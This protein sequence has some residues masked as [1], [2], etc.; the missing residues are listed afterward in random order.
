MPRPKASQTIRKTNPRTKENVS[1]SISPGTM[2]FTP[3][4]K[5][6]IAHAANG[7]APQSLRPGMRYR[8]PPGI[9]S[10]SRRGSSS[11]ATRYAILRGGNVRSRPSR[12][13]KENRDEVAVDR[14]RA[15]HD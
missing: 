5:M 15:G 10:D 2:D 1:S 8:T 7:M 3:K 4:P 13:K 9:L 6:N 14:V 12:L 11:L